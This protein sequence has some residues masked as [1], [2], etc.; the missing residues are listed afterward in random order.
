MAKEKVIYPSGDNVFSRFSFSGSKT[1]LFVFFIILIILINIL[2]PFTRIDAGHRGIVLNFGAVSDNILSEGLHFRVPIVQSIVEIDVKVKKNETQANAS[3][4]DL[5]SIS[6]NIALNYHLDP[7]KVH[8]L[9]K[10]VGVEYER[11][12]IDPAVQEVVKKVTAQYTASELITKRGDVSS[13]IKDSLDE[14]LSKYYVIV[15]DFSIKDFQFSKAFAEAIEAKQEAEQLAQKAERDLQR[16]ET[17]AKQKIATA[18]AEAESQRLK[19]Q[20]VT[21]LII[22]QQAIEKWDGKLPQYM[23]PNTPLPFLSVK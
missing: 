16:I 20:T 14:R 3:S 7:T 23:G 22:Q 17:E 4:Q 21:P 2:N 5:Q 12:I 11:N 13:K 18:K 8:L 1:F 10:T 15:D 6:T 9:Y 19:N